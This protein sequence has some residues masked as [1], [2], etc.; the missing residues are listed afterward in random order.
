MSAL[1]NSGHSPVVQVVATGIG[2]ALFFVLARF[3]IIPSPIPNTS[4]NLQYALLAVLAVVYAPATAAVG[5]FVGHIIADATS[6]GVWISWEIPTAVFGLIVGYALYRN[7]IAE[8]E[9]STKELVR[10]NLAAVVAHAV[11]WIVVAPL[12]D[13]TIMSEPANKVFVQGAFAFVSNAVVTCIVGSVI[14]LAYVKTRVRTGE[15]EA[16]K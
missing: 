11:C 15:L 7:K 10:F 14:L 9:F 2:A 4:I 13:I 12:L 3:V 5:G 6:Y 8:G 1:K 16:E